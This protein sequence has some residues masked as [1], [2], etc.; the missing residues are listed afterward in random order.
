M[1]VLKEI[2]C[3]L[4]IWMY[5]YVRLFEVS[6]W[7]V[8]LVVGLLSISLSWTSG[9]CFGTGNSGTGTFSEEEEILHTHALSH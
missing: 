2:E 9:Y 6:Y 1:E 3:P 7:R 8:L 4:L 5:D